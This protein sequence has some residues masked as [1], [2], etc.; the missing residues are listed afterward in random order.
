[1]VDLFDLVEGEHEQGPLR[2]TQDSTS[3]AGPST[4]DRGEGERAQ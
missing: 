3:S 2:S 4:G 1:L